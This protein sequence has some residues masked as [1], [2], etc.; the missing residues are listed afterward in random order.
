MEYNIGFVIGDPSGDGHACTTD[1]HIVANHSADEISKAYKETTK[2]LGFDF[3][4]EVGVD[5]QSDYW[6]PE[7]FTKELLKLG[8]IDEKYVRESDAEWG[9]PAGCYEFDYAEEEFVDLYFAIVKY[10][11]PDLEWSS[12]DL[13]KKL[14]GIYM[15]Q[16]MASHIM[17]NKRI[18][19]KIKKAL[20]YTFLYPR[21]C[22]RCLRYGAVYTVGRNSKWTRKA[23]KIRRQMDY[24]EMMNMMTEQL[25]GIYASSPGK[26]YENL[27]SSFFEWEV[28]TNF[29]NK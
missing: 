24:A 1:Y 27:D 4:K 15:E 18:P 13:G 2:L 19:R 25:K 22:G 16:L 3:I 26:S 17:E 14:C 23:A 6:I 11:L 12:R 9:A 28:E 7:K 20:K 10:S 29:I 21:V 5:F 8:I